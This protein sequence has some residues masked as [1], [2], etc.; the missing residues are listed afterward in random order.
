MFVFYSAKLDDLLTQ[1]KTVK[2][3]VPEVHFLR[4]GTQ[5]SS[6]FEELLLEDE[7]THQGSGTVVESFKSFMGKQAAEAHKELA[8]ESK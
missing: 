5:D 2:Q 3:L 6:R 8:E 4:A 7:T 1:L